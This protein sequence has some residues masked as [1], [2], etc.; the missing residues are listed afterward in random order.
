MRFPPP[1]SCRPWTA[2]LL[3]RGAEFNKRHLGTAILGFPDVSK[4]C[5]LQSYHPRAPSTF[6]MSIFNKPKYDAL[7]AKMKAIIT[8]A[9]EAGRPPT[10]PGNRSTATRRTISKLQTEDKGS[11][12]RTGFILQL[13]G[14]AWDEI[15]RKIGGKPMFQRKCIASQLAF[16]ERVSKGLGYNISQRIARNYFRQE[17]LSREA[18]SPKA[19]TEEEIKSYSKHG[20]SAIR[21]VSGWP[22]DE[23]RCDYEED[24]CSPSTN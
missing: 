19:G 23:R 11:S 3:R 8:S 20:Q 4:V 2:A 16:A 22:T 1:R 14:Q 12:T 15:L 13:P 10:W 7:P 17:G 9:V 21:A 5:M 24:D 18:E 6:P